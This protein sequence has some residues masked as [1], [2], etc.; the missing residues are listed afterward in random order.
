MLSADR[1]ESLVAQPEAREA[2]QWLSELTLTQAVTLW[3][4]DFSPANGLDAWELFID[5]RVA[6]PQLVDECGDATL[7][8]SRQS[9]RIRVAAGAALPGE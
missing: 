6:L 4:A 9:E 5:G 7:V 2:L 8:P 3:K 1:S